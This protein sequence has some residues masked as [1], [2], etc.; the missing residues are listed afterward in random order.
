[1]ISDSLRPS[2]TSILI[3][4]RRNRNDPGCRPLVADEITALLLEPIAEHGDMWIG[5][6]RFR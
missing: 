5:S 6:S 2:K 4:A 1:M 3:G